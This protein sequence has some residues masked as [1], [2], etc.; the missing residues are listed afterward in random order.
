MSGKSND[1]H[2][3]P[4][5]KSIA[6]VLKDYGN[7]NTAMMG[8]WHIG[9][10]IPR[11]GKAVIDPSEVI[12]DER[13]DWSLPLG[14]G[15]QDIGFQSSY[16]STSGLQG[17]PYVFFRD[18]Y[19]ASDEENIVHYE[20][21][22]S[23]ERPHGISMIT[24]AGDGD[25]DWDSTAYNMIL[26]NETER[27]LDTHLS[28][29]S[30]DPFFA[31]VALGAVHEPHS[32][33][34][35][36]IDGSPVAGEY[37]NLHMDLLGEMDKVVG[38]LVD[39]I[40]KRQLLEKTIIIFTSDNGG[41]SQSEM[42][43]HKASGPLRGYKG[44]IHEGG[45]RVPM[46]VR[47]DGVFPQGET[48][49]HHFSLT[50]IYATLCDF[51]GINVPR[52]QALD[53]IS[54]AAYITDSGNTE[55]L[56]SYLGTW[57]YKK[58]ILT[59]ESIRKGKYKLIKH[60]WDSSVQ[61]FDL[62][63]DLSETR[64]L[65]LEPIYKPLIYEMLAELRSIG[66]GSNFGEGRGIGA[67]HE[68]KFNI[69]AEGEE[70]F[71]KNCEWFAKKR[72]GRCKKYL[73]AEDFCTITCGGMDAMPIPQSLDKFKLEQ[74]AVKGITSNRTCQWFSSYLPRC[75]EFDEGFEKC[76]DICDPTYERTD[77]S[78]TKA[79]IKKKMKKFKIAGITGKKSCSW[80]T[81]KSF[82][83]KMYME[84]KKNCPKV[85][86]GTYPTKTPTYDP[87]EKFKVVGEGRKSCDWFARK[88]V[89]CWKYSIGQRKCPNECP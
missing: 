23:H 17:P 40:E 28:T 52:N 86:V 3:L 61:L 57:R 87:S 78:P 7:Y 21:N 77:H 25:K 41:L 16:I 88:K 18:G 60:N 72:Y 81:R 12:T 54:F 67:T 26:V 20:N 42:Y 64:D 5:Q 75:T 6:D 31:Y 34:R 62:N 70:A 33:P 37:E 38:S 47:W 44:Q 69:A 51:A 85:C 35:K 83:C 36:Y 68:T 10:T 59:Q 13:V 43:G 89:R 30:E 1:N 11:V 79:P 19:L 48:R 73:T 8:K 15:A 58:N 29:R 49:D 39:L 24:K 80:F 55:S 2:F 84:G 32:P 46:I 22:T 50:D 74:F 14:G 65:S 9:A 63:L 4:G 71:L 82:R 53:S 27:F 45:H 76:I 66:P 56:R